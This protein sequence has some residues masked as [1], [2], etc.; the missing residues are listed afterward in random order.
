VFPGD[1]IDRIKQAIVDYAIGGAAALG[2]DD[3]FSQTG[4]PPGEAVIVSRL[5]TPINYIPGHRVTALTLGTSPSPVGTVDIPMVWN[6]YGSF[7]VGA[8]DITVV[9]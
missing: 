8:I 9:P 2:I 4:F 5:Y 6:E 3:G 7:T 1:G